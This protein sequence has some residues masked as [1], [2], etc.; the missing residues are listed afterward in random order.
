MAVA[1][2][3]GD[4]IEDIVQGDHVES[5]EPGLLP[6]GGGEIR[7]WRGGRRG[8]VAEPQTITQEPRAISGD[9]EAGD[10]F[11]FA[12]DAEDLTADGYAD[13][14]VGVPGENEGAGPSW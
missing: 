7:L 14:I 2:V 8:P 6:Q 1:D 11:G 5:P 13:M 12:V 10:S 4:G 3:T 9:D